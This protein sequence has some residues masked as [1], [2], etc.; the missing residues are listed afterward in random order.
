MKVGSFPRITVDDAK[1][2]PEQVSQK[3]NQ[4]ADILEQVLHNGID[5]TNNLR[6]RLI[7]VGVEQGVALL[8]N[9]DK[10]VRILDIK[11]ITNLGGE[12]SR[13]THIWRAVNNGA[14]L[15]VWWDG[16]ATRASVKLFLGDQ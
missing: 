7:E 4:L 13:P 6:G 11:Q 9:S 1:S 12:L 8:I 3:F 16:N 5:L 10:P 2:K 14:E 15:T